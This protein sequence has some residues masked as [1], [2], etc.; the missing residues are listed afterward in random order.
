VIKCY[1]I[2]IK[3][4]Y[5]ENVLTVFTVPPDKMTIIYNGETEIDSGTHNVVGPVPEGGQLVLICKVQGGNNLIIDVH[6]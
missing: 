6:Y 2:S 4:I 3:F 1:L 5:F